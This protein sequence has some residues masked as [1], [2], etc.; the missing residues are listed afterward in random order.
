ME[1]SIID[2]I[3]LVVVGVF[4][5]IG[6]SKG[7]IKMIFSLSKKFIALLG[8]YLL[9]APVRGVLLPSKI[10]LALYNP[11]LNFIN[12]KGGSL[13]QLTEFTD[14]QVS[15]LAQTMSV[16]EF[17]AKLIGDSL[18]KNLPEGLTLGESISQT[19]TYYALTVICFVALFIVILLLVY[20]LSKLLNS[21][22]ESLLL[23][24]FNRLL[25]L[26][27]GLLLGLFFVSLGLMIMSALS[28]VE[29]VNNLIS[30]QIEPANETFGIAR[31][32]YN[33]NLLVWFLKNV[34]HA[35]EIVG[36]IK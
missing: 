7:F 9:V 4:A 31:W 30:T 25:G 13:A 8:S 6:L 18:A 2:I 5:I 10:G 35:D 36:F 23:K 32:L 19:L 15:S 22:F 16:P 17:I 21:L 26:A 3:I 33:N 34:M 12:E 14:E 20:V 28:S 24:P 1:L 29:F 11:I 27:I